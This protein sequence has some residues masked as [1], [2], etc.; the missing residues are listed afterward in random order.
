MLKVPSKTSYQ[1]TAVIFSFFDAI[2]LELFSIFKMINNDEIILIEKHERS[3]KSPPAIGGAK[4][5]S[6]N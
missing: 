4:K 6:V 3:S 2:G 1:K 5:H